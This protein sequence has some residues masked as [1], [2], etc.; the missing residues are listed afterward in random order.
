MNVISRRAYL[1]LF[2][3]FLSSSLAYAQKI[4]KVSTTHV[5]YVPANVS[6]EQAR[7]IVLEQ[8]KIKA[9]AEEFGTFISQTNITHTSTQNGE[10]SMDFSSLGQSEVK[11]EWIE[12]IGEPEI[13]KTMEQGM[14]VLRCKIK[15][16]VREYKSAQ[17]EFDAK[18]LRNGTESK[19]V[20]EDFKDG[21]RMYLYFQSPKDGYIA[22]YLSDTKKKVY[23]LLPYGLDSD[24][25]EFVK[26]GQEYVFFTQKT[27]LVD[28]FIER[29]VNATNG[30]YLSCEDNSEINQLYIIFSSNPF[31]KAVD[32]EDNGLRS[33]PLSQFH[34]WLSE[35]QG[36][37]SQM[38]VL[39]KNIQV[40][41]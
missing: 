31:T 28:G 32:Y 8:A 5:Y 4:K 27:E 14:I 24:G 16:K 10:S 18:V 33:L 20:S 12:T 26:N 3:C 40:T 23:C 36:L 11:G 30:V 34:K 9:I 21:D 39:T 22:V 7:F 2:I 17:V 25:Q 1:L 38:S 41:K 35:C 13:T 37:D 6:L 19:F 15:G 29:V